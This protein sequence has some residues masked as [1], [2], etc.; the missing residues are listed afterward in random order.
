[1]SP[2]LRL[3]KLDLKNKRYKNYNNT[4]YWASCPCSEDDWEIDYKLDISNNS[5][6]NSESSELSNNVN[7]KSQK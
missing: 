3:N 5:F 6:D 1:M 7:N 4:L 2:K